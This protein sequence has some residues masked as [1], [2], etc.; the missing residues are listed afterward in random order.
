MNF[1]DLVTVRE[2]QIEGVGPWTWI[3]EDN[4][5]WDGPSNE[6][7]GL[8]KLFL[9]NMTKMP[10]G[11][12][13]QAGGGCGMYPR[14]WSEVFS[15]V[16]TYEPEAL[17]FY[18]LQQN[19]FGRNIFPHN[20]ALFDKVGMAILRRTSYLNSGEHS[21]VH[22]KKET[23]VPVPT[24]AIDDF[25]WAHGLDAIQ[26]DTE[27]AEYQIISGGLETIKKYRPAISVET[28]HLPLQELFEELNYKEV[29]RNVSDTL[30]IP[31]EKHDG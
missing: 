26:L 31:R 10:K 8:K 6:F 19:C 1:R 30:F 3:K 27:G 21:L 15:E 4:G 9:N 14:L 23:E 24:V 7:P 13:L 28:L 17:N 20:K 25:A 12:L 5:L 18:C 16:I 2:Q 22:E 11:V 29:G